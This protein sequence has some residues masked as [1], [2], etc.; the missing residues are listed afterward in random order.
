[1]QKPPRGD[2]EPATPYEDDAHERLVEVHSDAPVASRRGAMQ[3]TPL[4]IIA[5][6]VLLL[7]VISEFAVAGSIFSRSTLS[8][9]TPL[10]AF[11]IIAA[12]GQAFVIGTGGIDLTVP[13]TITLVGAIM[14]KQSGGANG[15]LG[16]A[17]VLAF[18]VC[19]AIGLLNGLLVEGLKLNALV[20]TLATGQLIAGATRLYRGEVLAVTDVPPRLS[21]WAGASVGGVSY[22]LLIAVVVSLLGTAFLHRGLLGRRLVASSA[23]QPAAFYAGIRARSYRLLA[24]VV[25]SIMYG[26]A[27][28]LLSGHVGTPDLTLGDPYLLTTI[29]AVVLGGAVLS[30]GRVSPVAT[31]LGA[32]FVAVLDY[33]LQVEGLASGARMIVQGVVLA[34]A[35]SLAFF[36]QRA[37]GFGR[38]LRRG[39]PEE[40]ALAKGTA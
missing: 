15:G 17:L 6:A 28:V 22:L 36:L 2:T 26:L 29:V 20:V 11:L 35:L 7:F 31:L 5:L 8:T 14:V 18:V 9:L 12:L 27:G 4:T 40:P 34:L 16:E 32:I 30:G 10:I 25:A 3:I 33:N 13:F 21:D 37:Q 1:M 23:S 19:V 24:Y 38:L 39:P